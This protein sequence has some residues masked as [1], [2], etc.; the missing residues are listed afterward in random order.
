MSEESLQEIEIVDTGGNRWPIVAEV[1]NG[2]AI[3]HRVLINWRGV[4]FLTAKEWVI[5]HVNSGG[6][7]A[8]F[9]S[10]NRAR[11]QFMK[12][13]ELR[14]DDTLLGDLSGCEICANVL[15]IARLLN[16]QTAPERLLENAAICADLLAR[17]RTEQDGTNV[18]E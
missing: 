12:A 2:L 15:E 7:I 9:P 10:E 14:L 3:H 4:D 13:G 6:V 11:A 8:V 17:E 1:R 18:H 16:N 5:T